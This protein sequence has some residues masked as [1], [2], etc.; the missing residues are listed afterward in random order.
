VREGQWRQREDG[1]ILCALESASRSQTEIEAEVYKQQPHT[2]RLTATGEVQTLPAKKADS[3][4][5]DVIDT[6]EG[7][8]SESDESDN[9][10]MVA[11]VR[12][13]RE[14]EAALSHEYRHQL[15][16]PPGEEPDA[17]TRVLAWELP[18]TATTAKLIRL[19]HAAMRDARLTYTA[20]N[21]QEPRVFAPGGRYEFMI[22]HLP[23]EEAGRRMA[24][25]A[26]GITH[27]VIPPHE[28]VHLLKTAHHSHR[29]GAIKCHGAE[30]LCARCLCAGRATEEHTLH[31]HHECPAARNVW[32]K[33]A[34]AWRQATGEHLDISDP[35]LTIMGLRGCPNGLTGEAKGKWTDLETPWRLLHS[36]VLLQIHKARCQV[37]QAFHATPRR[38]P[39]RAG[40]KH[41]MR[42]VKKRMQ[43]RIE[44]EHARMQET[45]AS[46][47][48]AGVHAHFQKLWVSTGI[49]TMTKNGPRLAIFGEPPPTA[50]PSPGAI[51]IHTAG[52]LA[53]AKGD[54][55]TASG[56]AI[57]VYEVQQDGTEK[58][59]LRA[60]GAVPAK[61]TH[62]DAPPHAETRH[63]LQGARQAAVEAALACTTRILRRKKRTD[64]VITVDNVTTLRNLHSAEARVRAQDDGTNSTDSTTHRAKRRR[65]VPRGA[66]RQRE[67]SGSSAAQHH[68]RQ[69]R[70]VAN[71]RQL[72]SST[73]TILIRAPRAATSLSL[74]A[75]AQSASRR[76]DIDARVITAQG[77]ERT[78]SV[79]S[80]NRTWDPGD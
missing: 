64:I 4:R 74:L 79:W 61:N 62:K 20:Q 67:D 70:A 2:G 34:A 49:V 80:E 44:Y 68:E 5:C 54:K 75:Q 51:H 28:Q 65:T 27:R 47:R 38:E 60:S 10:D 50:A 30:A 23:E 18:A 77:T 71:I 19:S 22:E 14:V 7:E 17:D 12:T 33:V 9:E 43:Q 45:A 42:E 53:S 55:P 15:L 29:Q 36:I 58:E 59:I 3:V 26:K 40:T 39:S 48:A 8:A 56:W 25:I 24:A 57:E 6:A 13:P 21:W 72:A 46:P 41:V 52:A 63:P 37:H 76:R 31:E 32:V 69:P 78:G 66:K 11:P 35:L 73:S 16:A 1:V